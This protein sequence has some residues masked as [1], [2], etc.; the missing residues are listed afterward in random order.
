M[1]GYG[2]AL[3]A[4]AIAGMPAAFL[5]VLPLPPVCWRSWGTD[6]FACAGRT[7]PADVVKTR[8]QTEAKSGETHYKGVLDGL[9]KIRELLCVLLNRG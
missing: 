4:A 9:R 2:E 5:C 7:T 8:L 3:A 1:L 6:D